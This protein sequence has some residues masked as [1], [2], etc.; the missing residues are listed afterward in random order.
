MRNFVHQSNSMRVTFGPNALT[1]W[2]AISADLVRQLNPGG[3]VW[4]HRP[5]DEPP[6]IP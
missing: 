6:A 2:G 3:S 5:S 1:F 4:Y